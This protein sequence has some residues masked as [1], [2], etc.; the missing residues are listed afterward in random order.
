MNTL[1]KFNDVSLTGNEPNFQSY[2]SKFHNNKQRPL[3][4]C[5]STGIE[6]YIAKINDLY[7]LKKMP[8][9]G[10][11]HFPTC[12]SFNAPIELS[13][14]AE[15]KGQAI[16]DNFEDGTTTLKL[17]FS[18]SK[19]P[20][21]PIPQSDG[22]ES[23]SVKTDGKK[24]TLKGLLHYLIDES[25]INYFDPSSKN[26]NW[27][28]IRHALL[29]ATSSKITK[30]MNLNDSVYIP[31]T[32]ILDRKDEIINR[33]EKKLK[34]N[35]GDD[36]NLTKLILIG[37]VKEI[38]ESRF[39]F[40][41]VVKHCPDIQFFINKDLHRRIYKNFKEEIELWGAHENSQL[42]TISTFY[43]TTA[44]IYHLEEVSFVL[45]NE[46]WIPYENIYEFKL[47]QKMISENHS[48]T[49]CLR[50][51]M[52]KK[53]PLASLV[54]LDSLPTPTAMYII[55]PTES[56]IFMDCVQNLIEESKYEGWIWDVETSMPNLPSKN[57]I[58][59][60]ETNE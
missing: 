18:L 1:Y 22:K 35:L 52:D 47:I 16:N 13:G 30:R 27:F 15:V 39:D 41:M 58:N 10:N 8:K 31:E 5:T 3:C 43:K 26:K 38:S 25:K 7:V 55:P 17:D 20:G 9:S 51:N 6:M 19:R 54:C 48:F 2:L 57:E 23:S 12:I 44:G 50:Y 21:K 11:D 37:I 60:E 36:N 28:Y 24:L 40:K 33:R 59:T 34:I 45:F 32:F 56:Q 49:K 29:E 14:L 53:T 4:M 46:Q 42:V